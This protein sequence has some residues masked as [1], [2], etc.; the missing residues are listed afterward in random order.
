MD[1]FYSQH[2]LDPRMKYLFGTRSILAQV[3]EGCI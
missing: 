2:P 3:C 1:L